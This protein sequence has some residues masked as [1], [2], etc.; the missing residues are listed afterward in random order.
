MTYYRIKF[1]GNIEDGT[2]ASHNGYHDCF[3][4]RWKGK[5]FYAKKH[6]CNNWFY[7]Y[8][9]NIR[10]QK[11]TASVEWIEKIEEFP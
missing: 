2:R 5:T 4:G 3:L 7:F 1:K 8:E 9:D 11:F 6:E 10:K